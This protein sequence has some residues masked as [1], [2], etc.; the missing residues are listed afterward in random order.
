MQSELKL[1][2]TNKKTNVKLL[3]PKPA[4]NTEKQ[5]Y[6]LKHNFRHNNNC[7]TIHNNVLFCPDAAYCF[8]YCNLSSIKYAIH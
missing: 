8:K 1:S 6:T 2:E 7:G 3:Q 4:P 5:N